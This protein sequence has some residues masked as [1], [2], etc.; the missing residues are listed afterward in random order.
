MPEPKM[1]N[2]RVRELISESENSPMVVFSRRVIKLLKEDETYEDIKTKI[3]LESS[4]NNDL[5]EKILDLLKVSNIDITQT[6]TPAEVAFV[7][8]Q[9]IQN[10]IG[11]A[12]YKRIVSAL[13][14]RIE[15]IKTPQEPNLALVP[16]S[17]LANITHAILSTFNS[18]THPLY[19]KENGNKLIQAIY[20][21]FDENFK[22]AVLNSNLSENGNIPYKITQETGKLCRDLVADIYIHELMLRSK[23]ED[24]K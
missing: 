20:K 1:S 2:S 15:E 10:T 22:D 24:K 17:H 7:L 9:L 23:N 11:E 12:I 5:F 3:N 19:N 4:E 6:P 8:P 21:Y 16:N 13:A 18:D 14:K